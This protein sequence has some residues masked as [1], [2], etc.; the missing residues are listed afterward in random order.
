MLLRL[1]GHP[2]KA[3]SIYNV[4]ERTSCILIIVFDGKNVFLIVTEESRKAWICHQYRQDFP[5]DANMKQ[6]PPQRFTPSSIKLI[7]PSR[8]MQRW[9]LE[10]YIMYSEGYQKSNTCMKLC[11]GS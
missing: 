1:L 9:H 3:C 2:I 11:S 6:A 8:R 7:S 4:V 10:K 5:M